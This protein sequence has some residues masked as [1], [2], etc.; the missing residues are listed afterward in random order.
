MVGLKYL[1]LFLLIITSLPNII[2][3]L[4]STDSSCCQTKN[5][6]SSTCLTSKHACD[7]P[8]FPRRGYL[9]HIGGEGISYCRGYTTLGYFHPFSNWECMS[10]FP[11]IDAKLH[12]F[13]NGKTAANIGTGIR[14]LPTCSNWILGANVYYDFRKGHF[15]RFHQI[16]IGFEALGSRFDFRINGYIPIGKKNY[17]S[18]A[19]VFSYIGDYQAT[20]R[21]FEKSLTGIDAE[22]G[23]SLLRRPCYCLELHL[24]AGPYYYSKKIDDKRIT[25]G[26][27]RLEVEYSCFNLALIGFYDK[28]HKGKVQAQIIVFFPLSC[29]SSSLWSH[30]CHVL[31]SVRREDILYTDCG[32]CWDWNWPSSL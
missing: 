4:S 9:N 11:F 13:A 6:D 14:Y 32:C 8:Y 5:I 7:C 23:I 26:K 2:Q 27:V 20:C 24:A 19:H 30:T 17:H 31:R 18:H 28:E 22:I 15:D 29:P 1:I 16:G 3:G 25:G 10:I 12:H 21:E